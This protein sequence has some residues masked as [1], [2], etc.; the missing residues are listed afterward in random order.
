L[1]IVEIFATM[2]SVPDGLLDSLCAAVSRSLS[3]PEHL[4][5]AIW[6]PVAKSNLRR[7]AFGQNSSDPAPIVFMN[8]RPVYSNQ[9]IKAAMVVIRDQLA[10]YLGCSPESVFVAART[11]NKLELNG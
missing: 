10:S 3:L 4:T 5:W 8:C 1:P 9:E 11:V 2:S 7:A 6:N